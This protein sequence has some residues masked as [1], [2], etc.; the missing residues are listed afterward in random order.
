MVL[1]PSVGGWEN[2]LG[3]G[4]AEPCHHCKAANWDG[5]LVGMVMEKVVDIT[6][7]CTD[8]LQWGAESG[9]ASG[10]NYEAKELQGLGG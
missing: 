2:H 5:S 6:V 3:Q 9:G 1:S 4:D 7:D 10:V 8:L